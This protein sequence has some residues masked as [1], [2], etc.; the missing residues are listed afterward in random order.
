MST[1]TLEALP[2]YRYNDTVELLREKGVWAKIKASIITRDSLRKALRDTR[3]LVELL[4]KELPNIKDASELKDIR[5][6]LYAY[7]E[8]QHSILGI[9]E[10][11]VIA[12]LILKPVIVEL[13]QMYERLDDLLENVELALDP[14]FRRSVGQALSELPPDVG[15]RAKEELNDWLHHS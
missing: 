7:T 5:Q 3:P 8:A 11:N 4:E 14:T 1:T 13:K 6:T 2:T 9:Y 15:S 12:R 10:T